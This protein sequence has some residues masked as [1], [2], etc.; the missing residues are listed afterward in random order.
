[1]AQEIRIE[2]ILIVPLIL[3]MIGLT[4]A[5]L[6]DPYIRREHRIIMVI[7][8]AMI[9]SL[10][11]Q[12]F[13]GYLLDI[14]GTMP[15]ERT[16]V[17][18]YGYS[19]RPVILVLFFYIVS[20][21]KRHPLAWILIGINMCIHLTAL[22]SGICFQ[23]DADNHVPRGPLGYSCHVV[24]GMMLAYLVYLTIREYSRVRKSEAWIPVFNAVLIILSVIM[25]SFVDYREYPA[26]FL[27]IA[28][29]SSA[30]F[31]YI[32]LHLQFVR[33]HEQALLAEQRIQIMMSQIQPHFLYNTLSTIQA[34]CRIDPE[35]AFY[36]TERFGAYLRQNIDSLSQ[37]NLIVLKKELE[38]TRIYT[39]IEEIRFPNIHIE[40]D[41]ESEDFLL[42]A[43]SVQPLVEN[44]IR[45]GV[46]IRKNGIVSVIVRKKDG[47][48][49][50]V[51]RDN[52][53]GFDAENAESMEGKHIGV[54]N[55]RER[56]EKMC[57]G[58]L[59]IDS[60]IDEGTTVTIRIPFR[61]DEK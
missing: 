45:H 43:L 18:I 21:E 54:R 5:V 25:D 19:V 36:T 31:Y 40:Y 39:E 47:Y 58:T 30:V 23:I 32:W 50:I 33:E 53:K 8:V 1:M 13:T 56:I 17:G 55:V 34:L 46:R 51:I 7:I 44:A 48:H 2:L 28:V 22:F 41:I 9:F 60:R 11:V 24:S 12:N 16:L 38:H 27:T 15:Y 20:P 14:N 10:I 6:I 57:G 42:P 37:P 29:V 52:G 26:T 35:K 59:T 49:E 3:Q 4:F 61:K